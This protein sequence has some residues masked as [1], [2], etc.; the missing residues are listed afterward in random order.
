MRLAR[1][2][3]SSANSSAAARSPSDS[4]PSR[5]AICVDHRQVGQRG[6]HVLGRHPLA[7]GHRRA[8][9]DRGHQRADVDAAEQPLRG[10]GG[11]AAQQVFEHR[12]LA[13]LLAGLELQ[14]A[15]Q[16]VDRPCPGRPPGPPDPARPAPRRGAGP[17]PRRSR[18]RRSRTAP[19]PRSAGRSSC[20]SRR[21][22]ANRAMICSR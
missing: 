20:D 22:R 11:G 12:L 13:A 16:H 19:T 21:P 15:A 6:Q 18:R 17:R 9:L 14:L 8:V 3:A 5:S 4:A 1:Y 10:V 2:S 7:R